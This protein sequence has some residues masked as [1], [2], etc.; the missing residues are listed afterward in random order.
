MSIHCHYF[1]SMKTTWFQIRVDPAEKQAFDEAAKLAGLSAS[2][3][4]RTVLRRAAM[5]EF[6]D[7]GRRLDFFPPTEKKV[8][9]GSGDQI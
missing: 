7:A 2:A 4:A 3:W 6:E 8:R 9:N 5:R 1:F